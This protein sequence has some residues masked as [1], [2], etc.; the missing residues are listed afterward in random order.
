[1]MIP[2]LSLLPATLRVAV[3][4]RPHPRDCC[5]RCG[6]AGIL[7]SG[8]N[9]LYRSACPRCSGSGRKENN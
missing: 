8:F 6:G 2:R 4:S 1:M 3:L 9:G 5:P 7:R